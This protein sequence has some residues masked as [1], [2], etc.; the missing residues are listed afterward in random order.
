MAM[1][2]ESLTYHLEQEDCDPPLS[3]GCRVVTW[4]QNRQVIGYILG[5]S[6]IPPGFSTVPICQIVDFWP[7][8]SPGMVE[9]GSWMARTCFCSCG[10]AFNAMLPSGIKQRIVRNIVATGVARERKLRGDDLPDAVLWLLDSGGAPLSKFLQTF[11]KFSGRMTS[12]L[13]EV[14]VEI[15]H[16]RVEVAK[17]RIN[18]LLAIA[19]DR[20]IK[21]DV[22]TPKE[23]QVIEYLFKVNCPVSASKIRKEA[24]VSAAPIDQL[25]K[26]GFLKV[27]LE[28][29]Y[30]EVATENFYF[31][32]PAPVPV[33][34]SEQEVA[35]NRVRKAAE[36][37][38]RPILIRGVTCSGKTEVYLRWVS[39]QTDSGKGVIVLVPEISLTPQMTK[40]FRDRFGKNVAILHS[41]LSDGER[42][43]Q[44]ELIRRGECKVVVGARSA[45][46]APVKNLGTIIID[47][48]GEPSFK[49]A[50]TP[51]YHA[52]EIAEKRC[53]IEG[54]ILVMGSAT[55]THDS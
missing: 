38:R 17:P 27:T 32:E 45:V 36:S 21:I 40:R 5:S 19:T 4:I 20:E 34:T 12:L 23:R 3:K 15:I 2:R 37:D 18:R 1:P 53:E 8:L 41:K 43:D 35:L 42:F 49:Q 9:L 29:E 44:W 46:F 13:S 31:S 25:L 54:G 7:L 55:P 6:E 33:L 50:E 22:L 10:E 39:E 52:R 24:K 47:E 11:P 30:R 26:K 16:E 51:R 48:E 28:R 14:L